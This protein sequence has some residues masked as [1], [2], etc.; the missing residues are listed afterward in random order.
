MRKK[1]VRVYTEAQKLRIKENHK[2]HWAKRTSGQKEEDL[3]KAR[4]WQRKLRILYRRE[5]IDHYGGKCV[6]CG[7]SRIE[8]LA[9]DHI[10]KDGATHR[11]EDKAAK[12]MVHWLHRHKY[13]KGFRILCHNCNVSL[14]FYGYCPHGTVLKVM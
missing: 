1:G 9:F 6:C 7:E 3:R 13:P 5:A 10:N 2:I 8:F 11:R 4:I 14:G 12:D